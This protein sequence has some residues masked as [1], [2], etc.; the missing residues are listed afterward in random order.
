MERLVDF[1][2]T[3]LDG[4]VAYCDHRV[5]FRVVESINATITG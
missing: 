5:R 3:H 1:L 2:L 4:I